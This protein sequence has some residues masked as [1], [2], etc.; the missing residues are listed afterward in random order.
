MAR[1]R[2]ARR[3]VCRRSRSGY[4][5][6]RSGFAPRP[7]RQSGF[8][9]LPSRNIGCGP[10]PFRAVFSL[11][12][13]EIRTLHFQTDE[14]R[15]PHD[16]PTPIRPRIPDGAPPNQPPVHHASHTAHR[17][18]AP[19]PPMCPTRR[20]VHPPPTRP[21]APHAH[22]STRRIVHR[23]P[24]CRAPRTSHRP[25]SPQPITHP[26][27]HAVRHKRRARHRAPRQTATLETIRISA[28]EEAHHARCRH[29]HQPA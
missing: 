15:T 16:P 1:R 23:P 10:C 24:I 27:R 6:A 25:T 5:C 18:P 17:P 19:N 29:E 26:T 22:A 12:M 2:R 8:R 4:A 28:C 9:F 7:S 13:D 21:C 14:T 3:R 11:S 20:T